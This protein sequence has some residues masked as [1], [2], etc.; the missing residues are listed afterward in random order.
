MAERVFGSVKH[1]I[2]RDPVIGLTFDDGPSPEHLLPI[3][4]VLDRR[5]AR[6][7]FFLIAHRAKAHPRLAR[8]IALRGHEVGLHGFDHLP[9]P[10]LTTRQVVRR[11]WGGREELERVVGMPVRLFR[12]PFGEQSLRTYLIARAA[13]MQVVGWTALCNDWIEQPL[14]RIVDKALQALE[15]GGILLLHDHVEPDVR[16]PAPPPTFDRAEMVDLLLDRLEERGIRADSVG[17]LLTGRQV[18]RTLWFWR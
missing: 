7:T 14:T 1:A 16:N 13:G 11:V 3:L 9:L 4:D 2:T 10:I 17:G 18:R 5:R 6:A 15:P 8:E 12:P